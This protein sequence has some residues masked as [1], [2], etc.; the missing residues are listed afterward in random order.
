MS[1]F[2]AR[3]TPLGGACS[4]ERSLPPAAAGNAWW[5]LLAET[6]RVRLGRKA[7]PG[8]GSGVGVGA[9]VKLERHPFL[10]LY[11]LLRCAACFAFAMLGWTR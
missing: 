9:D 11:M 10:E 2:I 4:P 5:H 3:V 6:L 8:F 7:E 1:D